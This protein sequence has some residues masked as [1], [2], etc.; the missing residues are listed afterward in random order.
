MNSDVRVGSNPILGTNINNL[1]F[2]KIMDSTN[3]LIVGKDLA[4]KINDAYTIDNHQEVA[5][6]PKVKII[7]H[8]NKN[9]IGRTGELIYKGKK[10]S[11][12]RLYLDKASIL[13]NNNIPW[14]IN[15]ICK[16]KNDCFKI[17]NN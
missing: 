12:I 11:I 17:I 5:N 14:N 4:N 6:N 13:G 16:I 10:Y 15:P 8:S 9:F 2:N 3:A 7:N 1:K